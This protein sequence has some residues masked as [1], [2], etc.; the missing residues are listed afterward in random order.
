M[1][2]HE[3]SVRDKRT[4]EVFVRNLPRAIPEGR[5]EETEIFAISKW[6]TKIDRSGSRRSGNSSKYNAGRLLF[7]Q[8]HS[9][10]DSRGT[11]RISVS[12]SGTTF[13]MDNTPRNKSYISPISVNSLM[14]VR[15]SE[16]P[17]KDFF[18]SVIDRYHKNKRQIIGSMTDIQPVHAFTGRGQESDDE[19]DTLGFLQLCRNQHVLLPI[20]M[21]GRPSNYD[22]NNSYEFTRK[23]GSMRQLSDDN[24]SQYEKDLLRLLSVL[25]SKYPFRVERNKDVLYDDE[26][27]R[28]TA[29]YG[30]TNV[31][32]VLLYHNSIFWLQNP[33]GVYLWSRIDDRMIH[34]GGNMK[35]AL[36]NFL[37]QQ[38]NLCYIDEDTHER[39]KCFKHF[40][41]GSLPVN[42]SSAWTFSRISVWSLSRISVWTF[43]RISIWTL[44]RN[45]LMVF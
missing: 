44:S 24:V 45:R 17:S 32:P 22:E 21:E 37:F 42:S 14:E 8:Y 11:N 18:W 3:N 39:L 12:T 5:T 25:K 16:T 40:G 15:P 26:I 29:L 38:E 36:T 35:E 7:D 33:D 30:I 4:I 41:L 1:E 20:T 2:L 31:Y 6:G 9:S 28:F 43:S 23:N 13:K 27:E 19:T 34:G 10:R